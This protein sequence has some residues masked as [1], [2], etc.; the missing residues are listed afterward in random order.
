MVGSLP[1]V[2]ATNRRFTAAIKEKGKLMRNRFVW[3][4]ALALGIGTL[5]Q[6]ATQAAYTNS[7]GTV[8]TNGTIIV[9]TRAAGDGHFFTQ[10]SSTI[11]DMDDNRGSGCSP[12]DVAMCELLQDN[13]YSTKLL[14]DKALSYFKYPLASGD[15]CLDVFNVNANDPQLYYDGHPGPAN[16]GLAYNELLSAMLVV[17]SGSGSS[18]DA[19]QPNTNG[20]PVIIGEHAILGSSDGGIPGGHGEHFLYSTYGSGHG[21]SSTTGGDYQYMKVLDPNHPIMQGIPL[22]TNGCVKFI[23]DPFPNENAHVLTPGGLVNYQVST[24]YA[25]TN[26]CTPAPG[27]HIL[28]VLKA[29]P[30][31]SIFAVMDAG[32]TLGPTDDSASPWYGL[33]N[34]PARMVHFFVCEQGGGNSRRCFNAL[35]V[36]GRIMFVR[37]CQWAMGE[38]LKPYQGMGV[39]DV[40]LV[41]PATIRVGWTGSK[42][43]NYRIYGATSIINPNWVPVVDSIVNNGDGVRVTRTLN[44]ASVAQ[45]TYLRVGT[46][47]EVYTAYVTP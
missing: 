45:P 39:I 11:D 44:I 35:S 29:Q 22:D 24:T 18:S 14:P 37:A 4:G 13:G 32:G 28:G 27:L 46:L 41:S 38:T 12:G 15:P 43:Y 5:S 21:N 34:A 33:S 9:T 10:S 40:G 17:I 7:N 19:I 26:L 31:W 36:W 42:N 23:R 3:A 30:S 2:T 8:I 25:D 47:P 16:A 6:V 1:S 20:V